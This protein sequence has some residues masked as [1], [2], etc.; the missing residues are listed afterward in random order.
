MLFKFIIKKLNLPTIHLQNIYKLAQLLFFTQSITYSNGLIF[1][2]IAS[3]TYSAYFPICEDSKFYTTNKMKFT[4]V[5]LPLSR[6]LLPQ[7]GWKEALFGQGE[8]QKDNCQV[9][10]STQLSKLLKM[11]LIYIL[12]THEK[13]F[14]IDQQSKFSI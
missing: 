11:K 8:K 6:P 4:P 7:R 1:N 14:I 12:H 9:P 2:H 5:P 3:T 13:V 10:N